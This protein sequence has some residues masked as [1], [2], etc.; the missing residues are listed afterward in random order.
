MGLLIMVKIISINTSIYLIV[1]QK[2][3]LWTAGQK[4]LQILPKPHLDNTNRRHM[5]TTQ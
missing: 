1:Q 5:N 3:Q 2:M 4:K